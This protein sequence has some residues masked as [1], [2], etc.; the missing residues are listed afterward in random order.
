MKYQFFDID[1]WREITATLSRN[2]TRTFL[3]AFGIFWG[4]AML[5]MLWGGAQGL[6]DLLKSNFKGFATNSA[7]VWPNRTTM[8]YGGYERGRRWEFTVDDIEVM[9]KTLPQIEVISPLSSRQAT[10]KY[11]TKTYSNYIQGVDSRYLDV[12]APEIVEGRF[13]NESDEIGDKKVCLIGKRAAAEL[14]GTDSPLGKF[15]EVNNVYYKVV[16]V[17]ARQSEVSLNVDV[18][19]AITIPLTTMRRAYNLGNTIEQFI[20]KMKDGYT[21]SDVKKR[22]FNIMSQRHQLHPDDESAYGFIDISEQFA[23]VDNLF[24]GVNVLALFV[25]LGSLLAGIIGIGN[26]MW[27]I[28][29]ERTQEIGVR[30]A[31]GAKPRDIIVQILS[32]G[33]VLTSVSGIAGITF[34]VAV[35]WVAATMT[36]KDGEIFSFQLEFAHAIIILITFLVLG[37]LAGLIPSVKAMNIKPIE[38]LNDK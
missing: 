29:K 9:R 37:T 4:T 16:G 27:I 31:I 15:V 11:G 36:A 8:A 18:D 33:V 28:V 24:T 6:Q 23:T 3:T 25:G 7:A 19:E 14:F 35:L 5:A 21:P 13:I 30:R 32:E 2:K 12:F 1:N 38:A 26:I 22:I 20:L 34:A 17:T 10:M